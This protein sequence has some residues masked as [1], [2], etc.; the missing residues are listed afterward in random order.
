[1]GNNL[2]ILG[3]VHGELLIINEWVK[4][5]PEVDAILQCGDL[6]I[7]SKKTFDTWGYVVD[8]AGHYSLGQYHAP[9]SY[10]LEDKLKFDRPLYAIKGN[11]EEFNLIDSI[12]W[13]EL[14]VKKNIHFVTPY[15][16]AKIDNVKI[17]GLG[18]C[19]SYKVLKGEHQ[20]N[21]KFK[22]KPETPPAIEA[23][24]NEVMGRDPRGR[25]SLKDFETILQQ[26]PDILLLHEIPLGLNVKGQLPIE[27]PPG[28][29]LINEVIEKTKP[30]FAFC[31]HWHVKNISQIG[32]TQVIVLP[33]ASEGGV[34]LDVDTW[35]YKF[36]S[37]NI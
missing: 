23:Y 15:S 20:K 26:T 31:G 8:K 28:A 19:Y 4:R 27:N 5:F 30:R 9:F 6:G 14:A 34:I 32:I 33:L 21:K 13:V 35:K 16:S 12:N 25:I 24:F 2:L 11:H 37:F 7:W 17:S 10:V 1:M 22:F 29:N 36:V 3:D 18:G